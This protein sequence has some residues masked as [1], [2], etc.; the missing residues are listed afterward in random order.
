MTDYLIRFPWPPKELSPNARKDRRA[1][2]GLRKRYRTACAWEARLKGAMAEDQSVLAITFCPPDKRR[3]DLDNMLA[4]FKAGI[5]GITDATGV[6]DALWSLVLRRDE[7]VKN[8][9]VLVHIM[10]PAVVEIPLVG[11][12]S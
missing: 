11:V 10:P 12:I 9:C 3:R 6:D 4:S 2:S 7:P 8:G 5:D 1:I